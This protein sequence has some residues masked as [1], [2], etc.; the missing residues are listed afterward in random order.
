MVSR[1][2]LG[3]PSCHEWCS[4]C[5]GQACLVKVETELLLEGCRMIVEIVRFNTHEK[6]KR[7]KESTFNLS[8][9]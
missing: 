5:R 4:K 3:R 7:C 8:L 1:P 2:L 6:E 9:L